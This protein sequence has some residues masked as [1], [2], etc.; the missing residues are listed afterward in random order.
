MLVTTDS[1]WSQMSLIPLTSFQSHFFTVILGFFELF[2]GVAYEET[3]VLSWQGID[4]LLRVAFVMLL[5]YCT[6]SALIRFFQKKGD[7]LS[8]MLSM[9]FAVNTMILFFCNTTYGSETM[10]YRYHLISALP[11]MCLTAGWFIQLYIKEVKLRR[12]F[13]ML[14][15]F[16]IVFLLYCSSVKK[17]AEY[18]CNG[19][20]EQ[21]VCD[22]V[23]EADV[24]LVYVVMNSSAPE[25]M[26]LLDPDG[27]VYLY[28]TDLGGTAYAWDYYEEYSIC[29][30][31]YENAIIILPSWYSNEESFE[32]EGFYYEKVLTVNGYYVYQEQNW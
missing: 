22:Y 18:K 3:T 28:L 7:L 12:Y 8:G 23:R 15:A 4:I 25:V 19:A 11:A 10:E 20:D 32:I 6:M 2:G 1:K 5:L 9:I 21:Q 16:A 13:Y 31:D 14:S 27:A 29:I 26:R 24:S 17:F 30:P